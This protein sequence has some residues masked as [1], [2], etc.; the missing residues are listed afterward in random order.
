MAID[1]KGIVKAIFPEVKVSDNFSK[2]EF[3]ITIDETTKYPQDIIIQAVNTSIEKLEGVKVGNK[4]TC[5]CNLKG[6]MTKE[7]KYFNQ[8][9]LWTLENKSEN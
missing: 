8:I 2:K 7:G 6:K 4:I 1:L 9:T 5:R 3:V